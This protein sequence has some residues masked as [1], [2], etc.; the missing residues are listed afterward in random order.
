MYIGNSAI[1]TYIFHF[2]SISYILPQFTHSILEKTKE[3]NRVYR[4]EINVQD[5]K[6]PRFF[7]LR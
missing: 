5:S 1:H 4:S 2:V 7:N 3:T 6:I